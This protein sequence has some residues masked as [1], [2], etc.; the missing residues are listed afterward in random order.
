MRKD[1]VPYVLSIVLFAAAILVI[2]L[3]GAVVYSVIMGVLSGTGLFR[4]P[5]FFRTAAD[6]L[7]LIGG[8]LLTFGAF[9]EFFLKVYSYSMARKIMLP[10]SLALRMVSRSDVAGEPNITYSGGWILVFSG[11][12]LLISS[13]A[14]AIM[15]MK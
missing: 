7:F 6:A 10:Y 14:F 1:L 2:T 9:V 8:I 12:L 5:L 11:A 15:S 3:I 13:L 4:A